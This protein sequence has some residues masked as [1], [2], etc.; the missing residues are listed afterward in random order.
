M[1]ARYS[2]TAAPDHLEK[3][4]QTELPEGLQPRY[5]IA[6]SQ[7]ILAVVAEK[8]GRES[9]FLRWGL[10]PSWADDPS[11][12]Q[13]LINARAETAAEKPSFRTAFRRRRC[14]IPA[15][16][17]IEWQHITEADEE[18]DEALR[19]EV[20]QPTL[21]G[22]PEP[23]RA[24]AK[25][26][27]RK[28]PYRLEVDDGAPFTFAGLWERWYDASDRPLETC[29]ILTTEPNALVGRLHNRMPCILDA[30]QHKEWLDPAVDQPDRL[31]RLLVPMDD[32]RMSATPISSA[33]NNPRAEG[34]ELLKPLPV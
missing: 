8:A 17:F 32:A 2:L 26:A 19:D 33:I 12:G 18:T 25:K 10:V 3:L 20:D 23:R 27:V 13:R 28:Q 1:C 24:T 7:S 9:R 15:T 34:P 31:L 30:D 16:A 29:T 5:N 22:L 6:P 14:L 21:L 4:L 11:I